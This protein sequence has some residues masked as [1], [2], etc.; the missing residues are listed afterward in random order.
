M[1][2]VLSWWSGEGQ[3]GLGKCRDSEDCQLR[4]VAGSPPHNH[5]RQS[6]EEKARKRGG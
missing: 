5:N 1:S 3:E 4:A 2:A 6:S